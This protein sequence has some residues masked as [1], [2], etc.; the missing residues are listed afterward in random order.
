MDSFELDN[1]KAE[2][3]DA[4]RRYNMERK[5]RLGLRYMGFLLVLFL[6]SWSWFPPLIPHIIEV[7]GDLSQ[8]YI[9]TLNDLFFI[10][11]LM[12]IIILVVY[13]LSTQKQST[14]S[15]IYDEYVCSH[16]SIIPAEAT[17]LDK[18]IVVVEN[19]VDVA[20]TKRPLSQIKQQPW[21]TKTKPAITSTD[22][23]KQK[24]YRR[25]RSV[26]SE[27][28]K[29]RPRRVYRRSETAITG[30]ELVVCSAESAREAIHEISNEEFQLK[31]D[32]FIAERRKALMQEN[33]A[34][35]TKCM[36]IV[37]KN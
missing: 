24:E 34:H 35:Y 17:V 12:N 22:K 30:R 21:S 10:F 15:G 6:I 13:I 11:I 31:V 4:L 33:I 18:Q 3:E 14:S 32:S 16:R 9:N 36:S 1:V 7:A 19:A 26:V 37:V 5:L 23:V 27:S 28:G 20:E 29:R 2:K 8:R 25:T